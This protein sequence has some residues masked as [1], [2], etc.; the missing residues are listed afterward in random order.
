MWNYQ[1]VLVG[2]KGSW[3]H[4]GNWEHE[5]WDLLGAISSGFKAPT[6]CFFFWFHRAFQMFV[7]ITTD[8]ITRF[9][10]WVLFHVIISRLNRFAF[11]WGYLWTAQTIISHL[12][13][14]DENK[15]L[16]DADYNIA[17]E[18]QVQALRRGGWR[19]LFLLISA[20]WT[21]TGEH[22][23]QKDAV[24]SLLEMV[25]CASTRFFTR[26]NLFFF[27]KKKHQKPHRHLLFGPF[28]ADQRCLGPTGGTSL[29]QLGALRG[30]WK[31]TGAVCCPEG[32]MVDYVIFWWLEPPIFNGWVPRFLNQQLGNSFPGILIFVFLKCV[33]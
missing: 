18:K 4:F 33:S 12:W 24:K 14:Q 31:I 20:D 26:F 15:F 28:E 16:P 29:R 13:C 30:L 1:R 23:L 2:T 11:L 32:S 19:S 5:E 3:R 22:L 6:D 25:K 10:R 17:R 27:Q 7:E 21:Y 9:N 8:V